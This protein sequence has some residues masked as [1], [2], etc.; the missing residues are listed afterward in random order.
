MFRVA[1]TPQDI[2]ASRFAISPLIE[3]MH[4]LRTLDGR[5][6]PG[7]HH[8]WLAKWR[9][10]F[11]ELERR[12][13]ALRA[14]AV[15]SGNM[16]PGN[17]DFIAPPPTGLSVPFEVELAA[18][19][20]TPVEQAHAEIAKVGVRPG[21][22]RDLLLGPDVVQV[23]ADAFEALWTEIV[24]K[25]WP[26]FQ[27][28]LEREVIMRAGQLATYGWAR[29]LDDIS[30]HVRWRP[31][32]IIELDLRSP[33]RD[34]SLD[35]RGLLFLPSVFD[36]RLGAFLS[37]EWPYALVYPAR[38]VAAPVP[39]SNSGLSGLIGR[40]RARI[41]TELAVPATTTQLAGLLGHSLGTAGGHVAAL[42]RAGLIAGT[43]TGRSVLYART[44]LGDA[45]ASPSA[46]LPSGR[47]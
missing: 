46:P 34:V 7:V 38:G 6:E 35:G 22:I 40:S 47:A 4:A 3:T 19:R 12:H 14:I 27:A 15:I 33:D 43:R 2:V 26:R 10:P 29:A 5:A 28:I 9:G 11:A 21:W 37:K 30:P 41:L 25:K 23:L 44:P 32:G 36:Y 13:P 1:V 8:Q 31:E 24:S 18:M 39:D 17:V 45:L 42:R 20:A 16:G